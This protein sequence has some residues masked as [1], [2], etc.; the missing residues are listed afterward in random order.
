MSQ[1]L[2]ITLSRGVFVLLL[3]LTASACHIKLVSDYDDEFVKAATNTQKEISTL[4]QKLRN[5]AP[6]SDSTYK[7]NID[8]YNKINVDLDGL[9]VLAMSHQGNDASVA[10]VQKIIGMVRDLENLHRNSNTL[11]PAFLMQEQRDISTAFAFVIRT[12]N[13]KKAGK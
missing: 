8:A 2:R 12:E 4:L 6:G 9:L 3:L 13:D 10:Q 7:A 11:S 5:P 1:H